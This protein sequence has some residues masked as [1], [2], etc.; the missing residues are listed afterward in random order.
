MESGS[1]A[2]SETLHAVVP[3][4]AEVRLLQADEPA[5]AFAIHRLGCVQGQPVEW[6]HT[7]IRGDRFSMLAEFSARGGYAF[8]VALPEGGRAT[9]DRLGAGVA[10]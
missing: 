7:L 4:S 8:G 2:G 1:R 9:A 6:R 10:S 5:A 3:T